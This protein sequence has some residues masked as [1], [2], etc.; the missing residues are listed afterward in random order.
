MITLH[1]LFL[2]IYA[3]EAELSGY[4]YMEDSIILGTSDDIFLEI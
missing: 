2:E 4:I 1:S 3:D